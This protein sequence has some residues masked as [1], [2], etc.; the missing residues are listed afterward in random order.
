MRYEAIKQLLT[1]DARFAGAFAWDI[2][3]DNFGLFDTRGN[4]R[5]DLTTVFKTFPT[6]R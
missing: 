6:E 1:T 2:A 3:S 4:P 5:S